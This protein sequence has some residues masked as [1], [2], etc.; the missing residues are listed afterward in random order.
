MQISSRWGHLLLF[1][2]SFK[3]STTP[4]V[5]FRGILTFSV[6]DIPRPPTCVND[7]MLGE[8]SDIDKCLVA[9][10]TL[11]WSDVIM[12]ANVIG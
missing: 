6:S 1:D 11:V 2:Y 5:L 4:A 12:V 3:N 9:D 8:I 7:D 10:V